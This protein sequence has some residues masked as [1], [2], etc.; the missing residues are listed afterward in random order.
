MHAD[1]VHMLLRVGTRAISAVAKEPKIN[2]SNNAKKERTGVDISPDTDPVMKF[3]YKPATVQPWM[4]VTER[5][6]LAKIDAAAGGVPSPM[7]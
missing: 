6:D 3:S 1:R 4:D 7:P 5:G 2:P